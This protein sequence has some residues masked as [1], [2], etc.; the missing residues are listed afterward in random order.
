M[1]E[2]FRKT[3]NIAILIIE[4]RYEFVVS[5]QIAFGVPLQMTGK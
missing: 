1:Q 2:G 5:G 4:R 3:P